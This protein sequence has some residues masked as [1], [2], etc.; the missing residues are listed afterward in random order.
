MPLAL[1]SSDSRQVV[2]VLL[3]ALLRH[4]D[5][6]THEAVVD[7]LLQV[8]KSSDMQVTEDLVAWVFDQTTSVASLAKTYVSAYPSKQSSCSHSPLQSRTRCIA[9]DH[10]PEPRHLYATRNIDRQ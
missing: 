5:E 4:G 8:L 3:E 10:D 7:V 2:Y 9:A 6:K 1:S